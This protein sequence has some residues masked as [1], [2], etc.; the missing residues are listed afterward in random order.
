MALI[1]GKSGRRMDMFEDCAA[2]AYARK[3]GDQNK[4]L[5]SEE[6]RETFIQAQNGENRR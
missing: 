6:L 2:C 5:I 3:M 4:Q 1:S